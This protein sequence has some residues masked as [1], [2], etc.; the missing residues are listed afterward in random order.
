LDWKLLHEAGF[1]NLEVVKELVSPSLWPMVWPVKGGVGVGA[2]LHATDR[3]GR[4]CLYYAIVNGHVKVVRWL[5]Q[6]GAYVH[7]RDKWGRTPLHLPGAYQSVEMAGLLLEKDRS[8]VNSKDC[9][10]RTP[11]WLACQESLW[12][13]VEWMLQQ[14]GVN[15]CV[16]DLDSG[17]TPLHFACQA[18]T[19]NTEAVVRMLVEKGADVNAKDKISRRTPLHYAASRVNGRLDVASLL[20]DNGADLRARD[21]DGRT[22]L[23]VARDYKSLVAKCLAER[24]T[25]VAV[26]VLDSDEEETTTNIIS[27]SQPNHS[28]K[29][30]HDNAVDDN[31]SAVVSS[32][33]WMM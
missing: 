22:P 13:V 16:S 27:N 1:G 33:D 5:L 10:G 19:N 23:A 17:R 2:N 3:L 11:L 18:D 6:V 32:D 21:K 20:V 7:V 8:L 29:Q 26:P 25:I 30:C 14:Q 15:V 24:A 12:G 9:K 31:E 28:P 4:T